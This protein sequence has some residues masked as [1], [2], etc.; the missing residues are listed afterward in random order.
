MA[1]PPT[2]RVQA[3]VLSFAVYL[4][5]LIG[6]HSFVFVGELIWRDVM[7]GGRDR[8]WVLADVGLAIL[9]ES[10]LSFLGLGV[11][12]PNPSWGLILGSGRASILQWP[13]IAAFPGI[14]K[15]QEAESLGRWTY[16]SPCLIRCVMRCYGRPVYTI[17]G[18]PTANSSASSGSARTPHRHS[19]TSSPAAGAGRCRPSLSLIRT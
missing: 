19:G 3:F 14:A 18:R 8:L 17:S 13:H 5:P 2:K 15:W 12:P 16:R 6:P 4:L 10:T 7:R 11:Q 9:L 1:P